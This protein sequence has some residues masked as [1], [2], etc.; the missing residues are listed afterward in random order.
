[1]TGAT[2]NNSAAPGRFRCEDRWLFDSGWKRWE[3]QHVPRA[4][5]ANSME[6]HTR[7]R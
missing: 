2:G 3:K 4:R 5:M 6:L 1:M 7:L